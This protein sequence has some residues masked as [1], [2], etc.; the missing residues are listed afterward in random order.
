VKNPWLERTTLSIDWY[1][2]H[3][4]H[5][6][7]FGSADATKQA[8]L[9]QNAPDQATANIIAQSPACQAYVRNPLTGQEDLSTIVFGN[10]GT[11]ST[12]GVDLQLDWQARFNDIGLSSIPGALNAHVLFS[13]LDHFDT[14]E[15]DIPGV[16]YHWKNTLG[17]TTV[18]LVDA[19]QFGYKLNTSLT[20]LLGPASVSVDWRHLPSVH[21]A[22]SVYPGNDIN[23]THA[24]NTFG[25]HATYT[26]KQNYTFR[27][28]VENL[29]DAQAPTTAQTIG[30]PNVPPGVVPST[31]A[32]ATNP[33]LYDTLG[34]RFYV[35]LNAKF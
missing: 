9:S 8:C 6:I 13:Y 2:I 1:S 28:G 34:R 35:G 17:P 15:S 18:Y 27:A 11:I 31:G 22:N 30:N 14:S 4:A 24:Y 32:G 21:S 5:A 10:L 19:G 29:F 7:Q 20:Y 26:Y 16:T 33:S 23:D 25:L 12:S 3:I